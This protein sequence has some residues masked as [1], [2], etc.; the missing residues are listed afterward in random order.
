MLYRIYPR[1]IVSY[2]GSNILLYCESKDIV[3]WKQKGKEHIIPILRHEEYNDYLVMNN[4]T[5][6]DTGTY[7]CFGSYNDSSLFQD[8]VDVFIGGNKL[9]MIDH[10]LS[11]IFFILN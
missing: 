6:E 3:E 2:V 8:N 4:V 11:M 10:R 7:Y 9:Y 1:H 5:L